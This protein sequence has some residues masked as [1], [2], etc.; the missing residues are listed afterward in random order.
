MLILFYKYTPQH[1][2]RWLSWSGCY[3]KLLPVSRVGLRKAPST[4]SFASTPTTTHSTLTFKSPTQQVSWLLIVFNVHRLTNS[5][6]SYDSQMIASPV[7]GCLSVCQSRCR[8]VSFFSLYFVR[9]TLCISMSVGLS[10]FVSISL[11]ELITFLLHLHDTI[12]SI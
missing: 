11:S 12:Y 4:I 6:T 2:T 1:C 3:V 5:S 9:P 10:I 7:Y 8:S